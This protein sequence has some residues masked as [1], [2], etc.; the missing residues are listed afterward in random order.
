MDVSVSQKWRHRLFVAYLVAMA[1]VFLTP[2]PETGIESRHVDKAF[3]LVVFLGFALVYYFD[4]RSTPGHTF[5]MST[6]FAASVE[7]VQLLLPYREGDWWDFVAGA[8]GSSIA[9]ALVLWSRR[10]R[11]APT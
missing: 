9:A 8:G 1:L 2:T 4:R 6:M 10:R 5:L 7:L 3:H 11:R